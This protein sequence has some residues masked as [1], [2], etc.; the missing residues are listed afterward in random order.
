MN[1][2]VNCYNPLRPEG[3][4]LTSKIYTGIRQ[5]KIYSLVRL[6]NNK[7]FKMKILCGTKFNLFLNQPVLLTVGYSQ[8]I[9]RLCTL[10]GLMVR[11]KGNNPNCNLFFAYRDIKNI[12]II[13]VILNQ[14]SV[15]MVMLFL[16]GLFSLCK[17]DSNTL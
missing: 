8:G 16:G 6:L 10:R 3:C 13:S 2:Y 7:I 15:L 14:R 12:V 17:R 1:L 4:P 11:I 5:R 9:N